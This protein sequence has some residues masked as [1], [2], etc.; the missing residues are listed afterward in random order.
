[1]ICLVPMWWSQCTPLQI[2]QFSYLGI[3]RPSHLLPILKPI[4]SF[5]EKQTFTSPPW[6]Y[7]NREEKKSHKHV[8]LYC[9]FPGLVPEFKNKMFVLVVLFVRSLRAGHRFRQH[10]LEFSHCILDVPHMK[11]QKSTA[12][13]WCQEWYERSIMGIP[14]SKNINVIVITSCYNDGLVRT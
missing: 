11:W 10:N 4:I 13:C 14:I 2:L 12:L 7:L 8:T 3:L 5:H 1:M 9:S 6:G